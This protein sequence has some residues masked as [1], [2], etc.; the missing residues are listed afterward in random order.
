MTSNMDTR[1][2]ERNADESLH[3]WLERMDKENNIDAI[4]AWHDGDK[5]RLNLLKA[6]IAM[7]EPVFGKWNYTKAEESTPPPVMKASLPEPKTQDF[8]GNKEEGTSFRVRQG[9]AVKDGE[10]FVASIEKDVKSYY[11]T[12]CERDNDDSSNHKASF[13]DI[14]QDYNKLLQE[15][16]KP[17]VAKLKKDTKTG[18]IGIAIIPAFYNLYTCDPQDIIDLKDENMKKLS[19]AEQLRKSLALLSKQVHPNYE[20]FKRWNSL[21]EDEKPMVQWFNRRNI[22]V[23][24]YII[25]GTRIHDPT[26]LCLA[27]VYSPDA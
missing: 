14:L 23:I 20:Q 16:I 27:I 19:P 5:H 18:S 3:I 24:P 2:N 17:N 26:M 10:S 7:T 15:R 11:A 22:H 12:H 13:D 25:H 8:F 4:R 21:W 6:H 9:F 1:C